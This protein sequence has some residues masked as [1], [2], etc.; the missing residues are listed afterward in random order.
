MLLSLKSLEY[1]YYFFPQVKRWLL[2]YLPIT[3]FDRFKKRAILLQYLILN[4]QM[5]ALRD[6]NDATELNLLRSFNKNNI[7]DLNHLLIF[8]N[9]IILG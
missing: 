3:W 1:F 9:N 8:Y 4:T 6:P 7:F 2:L 5:Y